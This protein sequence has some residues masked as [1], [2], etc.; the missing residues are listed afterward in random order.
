MAI[1]IAMVTAMTGTRVAMTMETAI[2]AVTMAMKTALTMATAT[3]TT[4]TVTVA[5]YATTRLGRCVGPIVADP[6]PSLAVVR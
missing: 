3:S 4:M 2:E 1:T 6:V 5:A